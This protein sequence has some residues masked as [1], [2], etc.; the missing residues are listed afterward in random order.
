[1]KRKLS[2]ILAAIFAATTLMSTASC[3]MFEDVPDDEEED[4]EKT[5][6]SEETDIESDLPDIQPVDSDME[7]DTDAVDGSSAIPETTRPEPSTT[8]PDLRET[9]GTIDEETT[10][11]P[12]YDGPEIETTAD[13]EDPA[14]PGEE[15]TGVTEETTGIPE[16]TTAVPEDTTVPG[17]VVTPGGNDTE[18]TTDTE[19]DPSISDIVDSVST[20]TALANALKAY[21]KLEYRNLELS[22]TVQTA[23][24]G[25]SMNAPITGYQKIITTDPANPICD[26][27]M[28]VSILGIE[29]T[30]RMYY[31]NGWSYNIQSGISYKVQNEMEKNLFAGIYNDNASLFVITALFTGKQFTDN[32]DG[33]RSVSAEIPQEFMEQFGAAATAGLEVSTMT[34]I[35][36]LNGNDLHSI[37]LNFSVTVELEGIALDMDYEMTYTL[38]NPGEAFTIT[39]PEGYQDFTDYTNISDSLTSDLTEAETEDA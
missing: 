24:Y 31:E 3:S 27:E 21:E 32:A 8:H 1:M 34:L 6:A 4:T 26:Q 9:D 23:V 30:N 11:L 13:H 14:V 36:T 37:G 12:I 38:V 28:T 29:S 15:T 25:I 7:T 10:D 17:L 33:T 39:P 5:E 22:G 19:D 2:L 35:Y 20:G 16:D 18:E